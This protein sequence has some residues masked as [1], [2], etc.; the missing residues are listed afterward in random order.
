MI[1]LGDYM[2]KAVFFDLDGTLIHMDEKKFLEIYFYTMG[3][4]MTERGYS[5]ERF[6]GGVVA[7]TRAMYKNDGSATNE[8]VFWQHFGTAYGPVSETEK[9]V[10]EDYYDGD[11]NLTL[12]A[13]SGTPEAREIIKFC[14][15][16]GLITVLSTNPLFPKVATIKRMALSGLAEED[17]HLVTSYENSS[18]CK[19]NPAY[20]T[21]LL[22]RFDLSPDEVLVFGNNTF[23]DGE[24]ALG[25]GIKCYVIE[26]E[27][28]IES[29]KATHD[30]CRIK[31]TEVVDTIKKS[32]N[33]Q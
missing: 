21:D 6:I 29:E 15:E 2:L 10:M 19:P 30:F 32:I 33:H 3:K 23:E 25:A 14:R 31:I 26:T 9:Q 24:C 4:W 5:G 16:A 27:D 11:F 12:T 1:K 7:G 8:E 18:F 28:L 17:F 20:F 13:C 22:H